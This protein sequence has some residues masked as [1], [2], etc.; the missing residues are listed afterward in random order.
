MLDLSFIRFDPERFSPE[1][2]KK[3]PPFAFEPFGFAGKRKCFGSKF[4]FTESAI[5]L[6]AIVGHFK[7]SVVPG[8]KLESVY[9]LNTRPSEEIWITVTKRN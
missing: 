9:G 4:G 6:T 1:N 2:R 3:L 7:L 5:V 8:Q